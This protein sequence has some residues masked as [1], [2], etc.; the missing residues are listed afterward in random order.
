MEQKMKHIRVLIPEEINAKLERDASL[1]GKTKTEIVN[2]I[3]K[4]KYNGN[5]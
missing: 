1:L 4:N 3:L 5:R 2:I